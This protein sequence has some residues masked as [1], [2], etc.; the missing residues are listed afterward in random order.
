M[1]VSQTT[2]KN[3]LSVLLGLL[4]PAGLVAGDFSELDSDCFTYNLDTD[5][6]PIPAKKK[7]VK[8]ELAL[9]YSPE[10]ERVANRIAKQHGL[11]I[12]EKATLSSI[13][14]SMILASTGD[15]DAELLSEAINKKE[16]KVEA[17]A[18]STFSLSVGES[19]NVNY[20]FKET[21]INTVHRTTKGEGIKICMVDT[22]I[23]IYH[24]SF[25]NANI[26][27]ID[28]SNYDV[29]AP[30]SLAH[31]TS[32]AGVL[33]S[34]NQHIGIAP[35]AKLF[36]VG[37]FG[38]QK[39]NPRRIIG[40]SADIAKAIDSCIQHDVDIINLSFTGSKDS[41]VEKV[42]TK[43]IN[44]NIIVVAAAG[45][46]GHVGSTIYPALIPG[47]L[48]ATAT[49]KNKKLY[50]YANRGSFVD[51]AAP[52]VNV[53]T[54]APGDTYEL[55]TGTSISTAHVSGIIALLLSQKKGNAISKT[56]SDTAID[57]GKPGRDQ[58]FGDGLVN[59]SR[60]LNILR[61]SRARNK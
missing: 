25:S 15:K 27:T 19:R 30:K 33:V 29:K 36:S 51:I 48:V 40:T 59:A 39:N 22:P 32:V 55:I 31:G 26:E 7:V 45:N 14:T 54:L 38:Y 57:L 53:L 42:V 52:G 28:F 24:P 9:L 35:G 49:D 61:Q 34:Q 16:D 10:N 58:E 18:N 56:L 21:G 13:K 50:R 20:S 41:L 23:D 6:R 46:G 3:I 2:S 4:I 44:K 17:S 5:C 47:V 11:K 37:A 12:L 43:A 60:A 1:P 8:T